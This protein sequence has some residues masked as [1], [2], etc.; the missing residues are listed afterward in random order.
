MEY[1]MA[2]IVGELVSLELKEPSPAAAA[3]YDQPIGLRL[4]YQD[5]GGGEEHY[6]VRYPA[7]LKG[8]PHQH[9][10]AHTIVVLDGQLDANGRV[11]GPGSYAHFPA[12]QVMR[13]QPAG[14][15]PCLFVI[16][17]HGPFDVRL[18]DEESGP[19]IAAREITET[20]VMSPV[21][22]VRTYRAKPGKRTELLK[23]VREQAFPIQRRLGMKLIGPLPATEDEVS[24]VWLR[25]FP[26]E[27]SRAPLKSAFYDGPG[28]TGE[29]EAKVMPLLDHY[30][31]VVVEDT[32]G[33][34]DAWPGPAS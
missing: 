7:G 4:L 33:I 6:L 11:I 19:R 14:D 15:A 5:P 26:D 22:E 34:W 16:L 18:I 30:G 2:S 8:R 28:W 25:A 27:A 24:F 31:A 17:F 23:I 9:T 10:A 3:I 29:L 32:V 21:I 13:H 1:G 20:V 12:R